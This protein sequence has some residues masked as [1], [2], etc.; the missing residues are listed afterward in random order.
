MVR[1]GTRLLST[2]LW[3]WGDITYGQLGTSDTVKRDRPT[4]I[5]RL[6]GIGVCRIACGHDHAL[7]VS[8]DGRVFA[9]GRNHHNQVSLETQANQS[10]PQQIT[11]SSERVRSIAAGDSHSL[12]ITHDDNVYYI[13]KGRYIVML[14]YIQIA[15][16]IPSNADT[17]MK[18]SSICFVWSSIELIIQNLKSTCHYHK[19]RHCIQISS[20]P[21]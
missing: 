7:A 1:A 12:L 5:S 16:V 11:C 3:S 19:A 15:E 20:G 21:T 18:I 14:C 17:D 2:E 9:W 6:T 10:T 8:L 13:G 4:I